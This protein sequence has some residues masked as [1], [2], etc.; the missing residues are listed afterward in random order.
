MKFKKRNRYLTFCKS[1]CGLI[2][3]KERTEHCFCSRKCQ[4]KWQQTI[5]WEDRVGKET[6]IRV[7]NEI[8]KRMSGPGNPT[9]DPIIAKKV[10]VALKEYLKGVD[11]TGVKN[12]FYGRTHTPAL[13]AYWSRSK[14]GIRSYSQA[15]YLKCVAHH[16]RGAMHPNWKG[17]ISNGPY[18]FSFNGDLKRQ[19]KAKFNHK[20]AI[21]DGSS[22]KLAVHHIDYDKKNS[23]INNLVP[24]CFSCHSKTNYRRDQWQVFFKNLLF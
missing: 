16:T 9:R 18:A 7:R 1:G 14:K 22:K 12:P 11:R 17:G 3:L 5:T 23:S 4:K 8:S 10:S 15:G 24:L 19:I 13:K 20:C 21:C 6:A 2:I